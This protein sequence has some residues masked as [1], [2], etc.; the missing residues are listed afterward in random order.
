MKT[1][2]SCVSNRL[3]RIRK[4]YCR[5][6]GAAIFAACGLFGGMARAE[7]TSLCVLVPHFKDEYWLSVAYG[8]EQRSGELGLSVRFFEAGGYNALQNQ[9]DQIRACKALEPGAILIGAVSSDA[10]ELLAAVKDA[11]QSLPVIG[12]VN[13]L[14]SDALATRVGVDWADMGRGL[15]LHLAKLFPAPG[16]PVEAVLLSGPPK[17]GWVAPLERGLMEGLAE[18]SVTIVA[19]Y[20]ADTGTAEQL[21][22]VEKARAE[23]PQAGLVIGT[24]PAIEAAMALNSAKGGPLLAA[25]YV[26]HSVARGLAGG[27]VLAAPFDDPML[28]GRLAVDAAHAVL[29]GKAADEGIRIEIRILQQRPGPNAIHLSPAD[30]FPRLD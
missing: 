10:P 4:D 17:A 23:H 24:A 1:N 18:S 16:A 27:Q 11:A 3:E 7:G 14:H 21:R 30:Y 9:L 20:G 8:L 29:G 2:F 25:T 12:L 15:G 13:D 22:L 5:I 28:Q 6:I 26:S 19:T